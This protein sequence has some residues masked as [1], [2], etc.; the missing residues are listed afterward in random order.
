ML[1][2]AGVFLI[3]LSSILTLLGLGYAIFWGPTPEQFPGDL[4]TLPF[5]SF[6]IGITLLIIGIIV[7]AAARDSKE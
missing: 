7:L 1:L 5:N 2:A 4:V 3:I 6:L